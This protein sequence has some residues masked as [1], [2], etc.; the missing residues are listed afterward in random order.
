MVS[1]V[2]GITRPAAI[3]KPVG[4]RGHVAPNL[5]VRHQHALNVGHAET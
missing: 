1:R 5:G 2:G 3:A 4:N